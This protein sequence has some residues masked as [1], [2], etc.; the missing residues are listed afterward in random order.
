MRHRIVL[1]C[2]TFAAALAFSACG[3]SH[4]DGGQQKAK[5]Q[6]ESG[7]GSFFG[8]SKLKKQGR[9]DEVVGDVKGGLGGLKD[10]VHDAVKH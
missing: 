4:E 6:I 9:K 5:G 2:T 7:V 10:A 1:I 3:R 8:D